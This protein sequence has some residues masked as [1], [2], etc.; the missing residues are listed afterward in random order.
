MPLTNKTMENKRDNSDALLDAMLREL[1]RRESMDKTPSKEQT[2]RWVQ[3]FSSPGK[4]VASHRGHAL[5][6]KIW[7]T[8]AAAAAVLVM[9]V[10]VGMFVSRSS[11]T[12]DDV[13]YSVDNSIHASPVVTFSLDGLCVQKHLINMEFMGSNTDG[14]VYVGLNIKPA[15]QEGPAQAI[16]ADIAYIAQNSQG[17]LLIKSLSCGGENLLADIDPA[18]M[19][20]ALRLGNVSNSSVKQMFLPGRVELASIREL[21]DSLKSSASDYKVSKLD[22]HRAEISGV[23][24][25]PQNISVAALMQ[26]AM[27]SGY[28][29]MLVMGIGSSASKAS[30]S[31]QARENLDSFGSMLMNSQFGP[32]MKVMPQRVDRLFRFLAACQMYRN[33][34]QEDNAEF[35]QYRKNIEIALN[36]MRVTIIYDRKGGLLQR[37]TLQDARD[38]AVNIRFTSDDELKLKINEILNESQKACDMMDPVKQGDKEK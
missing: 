17:L 9:A 36:A 34:E 32:F 8:Y 14:A 7:G 13:F 27:I 2:A 1:G 18:G 6:W 21:I 31:P 4:L 23:I 30:M 5:R 28:A 12:A 25:R 33:G 16:V 38:V 22:G 35:R 15:S 11:L 37:V 29:N 20:V 19:G 10:T 3:A 24:D 26:S